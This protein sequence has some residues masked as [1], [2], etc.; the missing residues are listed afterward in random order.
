M[1][2]YLRNPI[3]VGAALSVV[4][5]A[6]VAAQE[7]GRGEQ[8]GVERSGQQFTAEQ[9]SRETHA[10]E[11]GGSGVLEIRGVSGVITVKAGGGNSG[12]LDVERRARGI[13][14]ADARRGLDDVTVRFEQRAGTASAMTVTPSVP[15]G[16]NQGQPYRVDVNY[17]ATVPRGTELRIHNT[18]GNVSIVGIEGTIS[19]DVISGN[20]QATGTPRLHTL[21]TMSG[22]ITVTDVTGDAT[23]T[24]RT[25]SGSTTL[26]RVR[27]RSITADAMSGDVIGRD[28][29][30]SDASLTTLAG[31][32]EVSGPLPS[33]GRF[34]LRTQSGN[35]RIA[36]PGSAGVT[37]EA[38]TFSGTLDLPA[39]FSAK[40]A[41]RG[42]APRQVRGV[43][44]GDGG[45]RVTASSL[46]G[47]VVVTRK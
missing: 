3:G 38:S 24:M 8:R 42:R 20:L 29:A 19:V 34:E 2:R 14:D 5:I 25:F 33:S 4:G 41:G 9:V 45:L 17:T 39:E 21:N 30:A 26:E 1:T 11:L 47:N 12:Q 37:L 27:A 6:A 15:A 23:M 31:N 22:N 18:A 43:V 7:R 13:T 28:I 46:N 36:L 44:V 35:V 16:R 10:L 32:V 40:E